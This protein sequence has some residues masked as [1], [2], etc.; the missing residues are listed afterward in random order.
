MEAA[1]IA[2]L[3]TFETLPSIIYVSEGANIPAIEFWQALY[4]NY[5]NG[6]EV[7][8]RTPKHVTLWQNPKPYNPQDQTPPA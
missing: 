6:C 3:D 8:G 7:I 5:T 1:L 4:T 2:F